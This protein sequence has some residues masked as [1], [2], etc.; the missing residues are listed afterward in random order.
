ML[1]CRLCRVGFKKTRLKVSN[2]SIRPTKM[3]P[4]NKLLTKH[5]DEANM[6]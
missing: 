3:L 6:F 5:F 4:L 2:G 1:P